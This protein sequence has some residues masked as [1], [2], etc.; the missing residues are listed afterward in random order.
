MTTVNQGSIVDYEGDRI[1]QLVK[2]PITGKW[3]D[4]T[5]QS[6]TK[7]Y[8]M[9]FQCPCK[10]YLNEH[11]YTNYK[12]GLF[13]VPKNKFSYFTSKHIDSKQHCEWIEKV[14]SKTTTLESKPNKEL[15]EQIE[16]LEREKRKDKVDFR[17]FL[18]LRDIEIEKLQTEIE[19]KEQQLHDKDVII[20]EL[21]IKVEKKTHNVN[22]GNLIDLMN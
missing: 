12:N 13:N 19:S 17:K 10:A 5:A 21:N 20:K 15:V 4:Q 1:Y 6:I 2:N 22:E 14:N 16:E 8:R 3:E 11:N 7:N 18:K 9:G